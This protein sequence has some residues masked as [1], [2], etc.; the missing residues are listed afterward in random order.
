VAQDGVH[1]DQLP[2]RRGHPEPR[3]VGWRQARPVQPRA[4]EREPAR[5]RR[6]LPTAPQ[7]SLKARVQVSSDR[8]GGVMGALQNSC[9]ASRGTGGIAEASAATTRAEAESRLPT[10]TDRFTPG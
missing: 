3:R 9:G 7:Q 5:S 1:V 10:V 2:E 4:R 6:A 8:G